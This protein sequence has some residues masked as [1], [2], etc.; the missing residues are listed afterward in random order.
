[1]DHEPA[2]ATIDVNREQ[3]ITL[4][5]PDQAVTRLGLEELRVRCPCADCRGRRDHGQPVWPLPGSPQPLRVVD[6]E[7]VGAWGLSLTW[8]DGHGTGIY[9]W[10]LLREWSAPYPD[11]Q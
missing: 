9:S 6:A 1:M 7:L 8:N 11:E 10:S 2:P 3:G 5:W 4:T